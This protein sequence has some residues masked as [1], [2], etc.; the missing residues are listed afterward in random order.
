MPVFRRGR[1]FARL[2]RAGEWRRSFALAEGGASV[3]TSPGLSCAA[4]AEG[5]SSAAVR[6]FREAGGGGWARSSRHLAAP[7]TWDPYEG[8]GSRRGGN[9]WEAEGCSAA[10]PAVSR[11]CVLA[12]VYLRARAAAGPAAGSS[13]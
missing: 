5:G 4:G 10:S 9:C 3:G 8:V 12:R 6:G 11:A 1:S 2:P 7:W 13:G